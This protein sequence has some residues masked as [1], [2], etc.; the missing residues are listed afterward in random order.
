M[1]SVATV[2]SVSLCVWCQDAHHTTYVLCPRCEQR[3]RAMRRAAG[4]PI[5]RIVLTVEEEPDD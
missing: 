1:T 5:R 4:L 2:S 3:A